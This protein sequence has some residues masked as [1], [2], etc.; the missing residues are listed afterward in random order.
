MS[1]L[2][3]ENKKKDNTMK[4]ILTLENLEKVNHRKLLTKLYVAAQ[5]DTHLHTLLESLILGSDAVMQEASL[6]KRI[7]SI[8]RG[9][10][11]ITYYESFK[12]AKT[13]EE[14]LGDISDV[15]DKSV[16]L[17]LL[18][19]FILTGS[20]VYGRTDDSSGTVQAVY[21]FA[22]EKW[23]EDAVV[24]DE[25]RLYN[26]LMEMR[27]CEGFGVRDV[28]GDFVPDTVLVRIYEE[29][30]TQSEGRVHEEE[31][32][33]YD[34]LNTLEICAHYLRA[35]QKYID[36]LKLFYK[37]FEDY[38]WFDIAKEYH[39]ADMLE[40]A[41]DALDKIGSLSPSNT[42]EYYAMRIEIYEKLGRPADVTRTYKHWYGQ[43]KSAEVLKAY[44]ARI[45]EPLREQVRQAALQDTEVM[46]FSQAMRFL[47][48]LDEKALASGYI[49]S[50]QESLEAHYF[51]AKEFNSM[52][53]WLRDDYPQEAMLLYR[54][55]AEKSLEGAQ[56]KY[57]PSAI[58]ALEKMIGLEKGNEIRE[59]KIEEN[60]TYL[61]RLV[62]E[63]ERKIKFQSLLRESRVL[64]EVA[65]L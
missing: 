3:S 53:K 50:H 20:K 38:H 63:H 22:E 9:R 46:C 6:K 43:S 45:E 41:L 24:L 26:D 61:A 28:F 37:K 48:E 36:A 54:N 33:Y 19:A 5:K 35:P 4:T 23:K 65:F 1:L 27:V 17:D 30:Y 49:L 62:K 39:Y 29:I 32:G 21:H 52:I 18:K 60:R 57:Y 25:E 8:K 31:Y 11:F 64:S 51:Y 2:C 13:L 34:Q 7:N 14:L 55:S 44:L 10:K 47:K 12:L 56:S 40:E 58:W 42:K 15:E 59:W 16:R